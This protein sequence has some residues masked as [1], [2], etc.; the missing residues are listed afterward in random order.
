M[1]MICL[2]CSHFFVSICPEVLPKPTDL[3][4]EFADGEVLLSWTAPDVCQTFPGEITGYQVCKS[5]KSKQGQRIVEERKEEES[6]KFQTVLSPEFLSSG[7]Q[8]EV[9][10]V[11]NRYVGPYESLNV[12]TARLQQNQIASFKYSSPL[13]DY[14]KYSADM[15]RKVKWRLR[16]EDAIGKTC[17]L[18]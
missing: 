17:C 1:P 2:E 9:C 11:M 10:Y 4:L 7:T 18:G 13:T 16:T 15:R 12:V 3:C 14:G 5:V 8:I 6:Q